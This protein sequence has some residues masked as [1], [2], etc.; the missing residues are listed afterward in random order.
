ML[1]GLSFFFFFFLCGGCLDVIVQWHLHFCT[2]GIWCQV[3]AAINDETRSD[4]GQ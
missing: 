2:E 1:L 3:L 4:V